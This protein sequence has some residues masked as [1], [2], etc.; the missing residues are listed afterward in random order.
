MPIAK[1]VSEELQT[2]RTK[3]G[4]RILLKALSVD[5]GELIVELAKWA[6][7]SRKKTTIISVPAGFDTDFSSIPTFARSFMGRWDRHDIAGVV[8]DWLY[9]EGAPRRE[10]D[11]VWRIIAT[12]G[13]RRV[14]PIRGFLGWSGLRIGAWVSYRRLA[15][16]RETTW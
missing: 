4:R 11:R 5:I 7:K 12:S 14:G 10:S 16:E 9:R 6:R 15:R 3:N 13:T 2:K 1:V 8:H